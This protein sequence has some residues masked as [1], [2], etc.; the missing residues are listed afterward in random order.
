MTPQQERLFQLLC[1]IDDICKKN[2]ITYYL[3]GGSVI[4]AIRHQGFIPW[5]D[6]IDIAI[7]RSNWN[8][9]EPILKKKIKNDDRLLVTVDEYKDYTFTYPQYKDTTTALFVRSGAFDTYPFSVFIDI[10][11]L[12]PVQNKESSI[13]KH[14]ENLKLYTEIR[15]HY[16]IINRST[17]WQRYQRYKF[18]ERIFGREKVAKHLE[19]K[20]ERIPENE[21]G[22]YIQRVGTYPVFWDKKFFGKPEYIKFEGRRF[23]VPT[24]AK[25]Y[26]RYTYGD[27]WMKYP[28]EYKEL[29]GSGFHSMNIELDYSYQETQKDYKNYININRYNDAWNKYKYWRVLAVPH[30]DKVRIINSKYMAEI[31]ACSIEKK[32][33]VEEFKCAFAQNQFQ[34]L[35]EMFSDYFLAQL[36]KRFVKDNI[37]IPVS[38]EIFYLACM[39]LILN[40]EYEKANQIFLI[41]KS[42]VRDYHMYSELEHAIQI[43]RELSIAIYDH[44]FNEGKIAALIDIGLPR[45]PHHVDFVAAKC[46]L[47]LHEDESK[48][49]HRV[50][51]ICKEE[52]IYHPGCDV[53]MQC[54]ADA[55]MI[56]GYKGEAIYLYKQVYKN[57]YNGILN[58]RIENLF[59][60]ECVD[61]PDKF[62]IESDKNEKQLFCRKNE[63]LRHRSDILLSELNEICRDEKIPYFLGG[64]LILAAINGFQNNYENEIPYYIVM[65][66]AYRG[67]ILSALNKRISPNRAFESFENNRYYPDFSIR[68]CDLNSTDLNLLH[69]GFYKYNGINI[70]IYFIRPKHENRLINTLKRRF[71][72][73]VESSA[74]PSPFNWA[75]KKRIVAGCLGKILVLFF[76]KKGLKKIAWRIMF[77]CTENEAKIKGYIKDFKSKSI[78]LPTLNF[79]KLQYCNL[80]GTNY[81][82]PTNYMK[83]AAAQLDSNNLSLIRNKT[84]IEMPHVVDLDASCERSIERIHKRKLVRK[85]HKAYKKMA[86]CN[87]LFNRDIAYTKY[88]W[89]IFLRSRDRFRM[90]KQYAPIKEEI[91]DSYDRQDFARLKDLLSDYI[92]II[93]ENDSRGMA[94]SFDPEIFD[95]TCETLKNQGESVLV[96]RLRNKVPKEHL[97]KMVYTCGR[98]SEMKRA[99]CKDG[100]LILNYLKKNIENCLY[101]YADVF[102]YG[103]NN[104]NITVWYDTDNIGIRMIVM[105]YHN[106]FQVYSDR[107]FD[108]IRGLIKLVDSQK[109]MG[110]SGRKEI[111]LELHKFVKE[112]YKADYGVIF[113]GKPIDLDKVKN[114][115]KDCNV[116]IE[117]AKEE[118]TDN[119]AQLLCMDEELG[120]VYTEKSMSEELKER[121]HTQMGRSYIIRNNNE[122]VAHNATYAECDKFVIC[123]GLMV[124]PDFRNTEYAYWLD[125]KA[126]I[127]FYEEGKDRYF[128]ALKD[129]IIHMNKLRGAEIVAEYG[130]LSLK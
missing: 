22:G 99:T 102:K 127:E 75:Y 71:Y 117:L 111:I 38:D 109:P 80:N 74:Y 79:N 124:H 66:P 35:Y 3:H 128:L 45:Y 85:Y 116:D 64:R 62:K 60:K 8:R 101:I 73:I 2:N 125:L 6:D 34:K 77:K 88:S 49:V 57:T 121:I 11:I 82:I 4:G 47:L 129:K 32:L 69:K 115:L 98:V 58:L 15:C 20:L 41:N 46:I 40:G 52:L 110:V 13:K 93:K 21:G 78:K 27:G 108:D 56:L 91:L 68:Y 23:P 123:S 54:L 48:N 7:T 114:G 37:P 83:Y 53:L 107:G 25:E 67:K 84:T 51:N 89:N 95:I 113:R 16:Y 96:N 130:K 97:K 1:E 122:I 18:F 42:I 104:R 120:A 14:Q 87:I 17:N 30:E 72:T 10:L 70:T 50:I 5:D 92:E 81:S 105:K 44:E 118:D 90:Y 112:S 28:Y 65:H 100:K 119:I 76:G 9:L 29:M 24:Q 59:R 39:V 94:L 43:T 36:D 55:K 61:L 126:C 86:K 106:N 63:E 26:L 19:K 33:R 103:V 31:K 12:D